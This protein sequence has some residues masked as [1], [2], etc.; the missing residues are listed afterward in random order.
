MTAKRI[1]VSISSKSQHWPQS[2][3]SAKAAIDIALD[4]VKRQG[5]VPRDNEMSP[6]LLIED[7]WGSRT[8]IVFDVLHDTYRSETAHLPSEGNLP[9]IVVWLSTTETAQPATQGIENRV[10][11]EVRQ[12]HTLTDAGGVPP[13]VFDRSGGAYPIFTNP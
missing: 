11:D 6:R 10:N 4:L 9:V 7:K 8:H 2:C 12:W 5:L 13:F 3:E 1:F